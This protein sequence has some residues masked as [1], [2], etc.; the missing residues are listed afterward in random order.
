[1]S[2]WS[3]EWKRK[4]TCKIIS[5]RL[6]P[7]SGIS[8]ICSNPENIG[9]VTDLRRF[10]SDETVASAL[11]AICGG[12]PKKTISNVNLDTEILR[13]RIGRLSGGESYRVALAAQLENRAPILVLDAPSSMLD[14]RSADSL[15]EA[16]ANREEALLVF[17]ADITVAIETCQTAVLLDKGEVVASGPTIEILTDSELLKQH[18]V[19]MP[20]ALFKLATPQNVAKCSRR[21]SIQEF[22]EVERTAKDIAEQAAKFFSQFRSDFLDVTQ[23]ARDNFANQ[24]FAQHQINS[25]LRLLLHRQLVNNALKLLTRLL[26]TWKRA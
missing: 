22:G 8:G 14:A 16:L 4:S 23:R 13:R 24:E 25:H 26:K 2:P 1:M 10:N 12:D 18:G 20:S 19:D 15:V 11:Q 6:T 3:G 5:Q 9:T 17:T 21:C 7:T